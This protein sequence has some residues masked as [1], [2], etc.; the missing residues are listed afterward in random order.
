MAENLGSWDSLPLDEATA[1][2]AQAPFRWWVTGGHALELHCNRSWRQHDDID[3]SL[4]RNDAHL[5]PQVLTGWD[6]HVAAAGQLRPWT[7][8]EL[9]AAA[10]ENNLW[11][12]R[13]PSEPWCLDLTIADGDDDQW[14]FRRDRRISRRWST[15]VLWSTHDDLPYLAPDLQLLYKSQDPRPKDD[16]DV[17]EVVPD[18]T[19]AQSSFLFDALGEQHPWRGYFEQI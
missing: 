2:F 10:S 9:K 11:V 4:C 17:Q 13:A 7:G 18:L 6:V 5:L 16:I 12:R 19:D 15:T 1:L 3:I 14:I 8:H